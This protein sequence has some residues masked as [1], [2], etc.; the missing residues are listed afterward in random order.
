MKI[1]EIRQL[2]AW[3]GE[4]G[5]TTLE[6]KR[7]D[8]SLLLRRAAQVG[9]G[10]RPPV[11]TPA[12]ERQPLVVSASGPGLFL[13]SHPDEAAPY[14]QMGDVISPGQLVGVLRVGTL[15]LPVRAAVAGRVRQ[16]SAADGQIVGYGQALIELEEL[17]A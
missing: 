5:L 10:V 13:A 17:A 1:D 12:L 3:L 7:G 11:V 6:L 14:V 2:A 15:F 16:V 8:E 9:W 4:A